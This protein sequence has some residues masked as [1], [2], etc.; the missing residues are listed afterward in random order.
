MIRDWIA[1]HRRFQN[2]TAASRE[3]QLTPQEQYA[4]RHHL[5]N[6]E[7][8]GVPN[9]DGSISSFLN[10]TTE[11]NG[12]T[13]VIPKVWDNKILPDDQAEQRAIA[14]GLEKWPTYPTW[15]E[16]D[17]RYMQMHNYMSRDTES[18]LNARSNRP[19]Q[20]TDPGSVVGPQSTSPTGLNR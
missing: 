10:L 12:K 13:Y 6:L 4:Y 14:D 11:I 15:Q 20:P 16:G 8:G 1:G 19:I 2:Y 7:R 17:A 9:D 5:S 3:M 18:K